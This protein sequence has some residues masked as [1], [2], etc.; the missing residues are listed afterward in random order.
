MNFVTCIAPRPRLMR[1]APVMVP[2]P[3]ERVGLPAAEPLPPALPAPVAPVEAA[4]PRHTP[5]ALPLALPR[6]PLNLPPIERPWNFSTVLPTTAP[7]L[8]AVAVASGF[9]LAALRRP[10]RAA[11][12]VQARQTA[13]FVIRRF[14]GRSLPSIGDALGGRHH[15]TVLHACRQV[16]RV[17]ELIGEPETDTVEAWI[18]HL[19]RHHWK[20]GK[21]LRA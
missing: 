15:T 2:V 18:S 6:P 1:G 9:S 17:V 13:C 12:I 4:E 20:S 21:E 10:G 7:I 16:E 5:V 14:T 3:R 19:L 8:Q 11:P